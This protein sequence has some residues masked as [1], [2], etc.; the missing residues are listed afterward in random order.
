VRR[1]HSGQDGGRPVYRPG[2]TDERAWL[3]AT[4]QAELVRRGE[5]TPRELVDAAIDRI[6]RLDPAVNAVIHPRFEKARAEA[7]AGLP[8][9]PFTGVPFVLKDLGGLSRGDPYHAGTRVLRAL[10]H[11]AD[12]DSYL[13][14]KFW[15]AGFI[16]VGRTNV[17]ELGTT[18]TTESKAW[19]PARNPWDVD[20]STGGS[21][22]GSGAAV[23]AGMVAVGHA[24][25]GGG[26]IR[27]PAANCG[28]VGLKPSR[29]RVSNGPDSGDSWMGA[30]IEGAVTRSVRDAAAVL[31]AIAGYMPGDPYTAPPPARPFA[32]EVGTDPGSLRIGLL[33][34][35]LGADLTAD[36]DCAEAVHATGKLLESLGH[37]VEVAHPAALEETETARRFG[38]IVAAWTAAD[39]ADIEAIAGR[40]L[41]EDDIEPEN[42]HYLD[43]GRHMP[44]LDYVAGEVWLQRWCR[45]VVE[46]W[47]PLD[48]SPGF[49]ILVSPVLNGPP[50]PLGYITDAEHGLDRMLD[51]LQYTA[52]FNVT[53][54]PAVSLPL[55]WT[56]DDLPI[57]V[58]FVGGFAREDVLIRLAAQL[59][60]AQPWADRHPPLEA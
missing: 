51:L 57:G 49:D 1:A 33:D 9:G 34:H 15:D 14:A 48:G 28:L 46:W 40:P 31:D 12:H 21:S 19:G 24:N 18:I 23:A 53:G 41:T 26:S 59:E 42:L 27:I 16:C 58:Q 13:T 50:P 38:L 52:Q 32:A 3:D 56:A 22:G 60:A 29:A 45:R 30:T 17:C 11:R 8:D 4:A 55:H 2:V 6:E 44:A 25:D 20:R 35:P 10:D 37:R 36:P 47:H 54:Q 5:A 7:D 39:I 43:I